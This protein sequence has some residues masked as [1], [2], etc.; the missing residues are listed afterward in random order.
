MSTFQLIPTSLG[1]YPATATPL[2]LE[3]RYQLTRET[4][5]WRNI[6][7]V[8][9][10]EGFILPA[11]KTGLGMATQSVALDE[12]GFWQTSGLGDKARM[13]LG[14]TIYYGVQEMA[15]RVIG[16]EDKTYISGGGIVPNNL[17]ALQ[18]KGM[19]KRAY[20]FSFQLYAYDADDMT[21]I[22]DFVTGMHALSMPWGGSDGGA[23]LYA[24]AVFQPRILKADMSTEAIGWLLNPKPCTMLT[25]NSSGGQ[26]AVQENGGPAVVTCSMLLAEIEPV[27]WNGGVITQ[28]EFFN[29]EAEE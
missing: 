28:G 22:I 17:S 23:K 5:Q 13:V 10:S 16:G 18:Y 25:F 26:Y 9:G 2:Y 24:P 19:K 8:D 11:P 29:L 15:N 21:S 12:V 6:V 20:N 27:L 3:L 14:D 4:K 7:E 1:Q